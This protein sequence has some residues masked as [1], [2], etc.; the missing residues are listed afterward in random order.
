M[1][2]VQEALLGVLGISDELKARE[3]SW[4]TEK[5]QIET[6]LSSLESTNALLQRELED[7]D[8][9]NLYD[10][11]NIAEIIPQKNR[12]ATLNRLRRLRQE[13]PHAKQGVQLIK[14]FTLG[15]GVQWTTE[16]SAVRD[17]IR[18]FWRDPENE[19]VLTTHAAQGEVLDDVVTDGERFL[20]AFDSPS[21]AP[22]VKLADIPAE[23]IKQT[24]YH[25]DNR[26]IPVWYKRVYVE[27]TFDG[28]NDQYNLVGQPI[29][30]YYL[31]HRITEKQ[32]EEIK[33]I[34]I[35]TA[36]QALQDNGKPVKIFHIFRNGIRG[37]AGVRGISELYASREWFKVFKEFMQDRAAINAAATAIAAKRKVKGGP[38]EVAKFT[39]KLAGEDIGYDSTNPIRS[40]RRPV[41]GAIYDSNAAVDLEWMKTDTGASQ[42]KEDAR[43]LLMT[44][45]IG[46]GTSVHYYGEG[47][48][49]NLA[50]AQAM[51]LP[52][53]KMFED[54][55]TF[56][57]ESV[58]HE[59][60]R[61]VLGVAF[62]NGIQK[63]PTIAQE[64]DSGDTADLPGVIAKDFDPKH[65]EDLVAWSF[66]PIIAK[67]IVKI[68]SA[69]AAFVTQIAPDNGTAGL[70]A[71]RQAMTALEIPNMDQ[72]LK[73]V[74]A[75]QRVI[76]TEKKAAQQ[77]ARANLVN[78]GGPVPP[79]GNGQNGN[80]K[81]KAPQTGFVKIAGQGVDAGTKR[82]TKG[83]PP[84][85]HSSQ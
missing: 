7:I 71:I 78:G 68:I 55:Q 12:E 21:V 51:E 48:D 39:G 50:T 41:A 5:E 16:H 27:Q 67:D 24:I 82:I 75:E 58:L 47:G 77:A 52:M 6:Q 2:P 13:N 81:K 15:R 43:M 14:I 25:P 33:G 31:D 23:E 1:N 56:W 84:I 34:K 54:W 40:L 37:K 64:A 20:A 19:A 36:K 38:A 46:L 62:P 66:P 32:L 17:A 76:Q 42:A 63:D 72:I 11:P 30:R 80:G 18:E 73:A 44:A 61:Y 22:Y 49:A 70:A 9:L 35:P 74:E 60:I 10:I 85:D 69:I 59:V 29:T 8:Y 57:K 26:R 4:N 45:G 83:K 65:P 53:V 28:A 79:A 3:E